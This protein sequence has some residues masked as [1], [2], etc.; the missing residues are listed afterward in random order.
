MNTYTTKSGKTYTK[1]QICEAIKFWTKQLKKL[2]EGISAAAA[3]NEYY[4]IVASLESLDSDDSDAILSWADG[5]D[6]ENIKFFGGD[7]T[8][9]EALRR[10]G[11]EI[12]WEHGDIEDGLED[13]GELIFAIEDACDAFARAIESR[14]SKSIVKEYNKFI[15]LEK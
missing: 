10:L 4:G 6:T 7:E 9:L 5:K 8:N 14:D 12:S 3:M 2:N 1:K 11:Q 13:G 15:S